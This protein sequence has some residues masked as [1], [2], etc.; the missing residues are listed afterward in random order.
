MNDYALK[1]GIILHGTNYNYT[2]EKVLGNGSFG[3]TYLA[4]VQMKGALGSL[5]ANISVAIKE[6]FMRDFNGRDECTVTYSSSDG[7]FTN[8]YKSRFIQEAKNLSKLHN[9]NIIKVIELFE[10]NQTAYY[11]MEYLPKGNFNDYIAAHKKLSAKDCIEYALQISGALDYMHDNGMLHLDLK[12]NNIMI[13]NNG[14]LVL[15]DFGLSKCFDQHG[16]PE[17]ST[18]IGHGTPGYAPIEQANYQ[19]TPNEG[20]PAT[21]DIYAF[22]AT[23]FKM[24]TGR[25]PPEASVILNDSFPNNDLV[26]INV[27]NDV[28]SVVRKCMQPIRNNRY[29]SMKDVI[30]AL[31]SI[32]S[33]FNDYEQSEFS[34]RGYYR[35]GVGERE[36]GTYQIKKIPVTSAIEFPNSINIRLWDNTGY[37]DSYE[38]YLTDIFSADGD[39]FSQNSI[40]FWHHG[41]F[42]SEYDFA[43]GIPSDVKDFIIKNGLLSTVHWELEDITTPIDNN[44]G[45]NLCIT[46]YNG[47]DEPFIRHVGNAHKAFHTI[48]LDV[49]Q[50]LLETTSLANKLSE[51]R[52]Q[53][54]THR[55]EIPFDS[56]S[57]SVKYKPAFL[58]HSLSSSFEYTFQTYPNIEYNNLIVV[59]NLLPLI[60]DINNLDIKEGMTLNDSHDYSEDPAELVI[61]VQSP[62]K[63]SILL[64]LKA[65]NRDMIAGNIYHAK[66]TDLAES[67]H[68][69][70]LKYLPK[71][72]EPTQELIYSIPE[73]T[74]EIRI[75]YSEGGIIGLCPNP[76]KIRIVNNKRREG[77]YS[78]EEL[79]KIAIGLQNLKLRSKEKID[80]EPSTGI[81]F[82]SLTLS[83]VDSH[84]KIL[85]ELYAQDNGNEMIGNTAIRVNDLKDELSKLSKS[86]KDS[87]AENEQNNNPKQSASKQTFFDIIFDIIFCTIILGVLAIPNFIFLKPT[88]KLFA[89]LWATFGISELFISILNMTLTKFPKS[90]KSGEIFGLLG[91]LSLIAYI[92]LWITQIF[93]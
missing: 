5:D 12:P 69:I 17:T 44:F 55:I 78:P 15:I 68:R 65:F 47:S 66:I 57:I 50:E 67:I 70:V 21:M 82:P 38:I 81:V 2:I 31:K 60:R 83:F 26:S 40:K 18:T 62:S 34:T 39:L 42:V 19:G 56:T 6:F 51:V 74:S 27:P 84:G 32:P 88:D 77:I 92:I 29:K 9:S 7:A 64:F 36:Y 93:I 20:F 52:K 11:V 48:L 16:K 87:L 49:I 41:H 54:N 58:M 72:H 46:M 90:K 63:G 23:M 33:S 61:E 37:G 85:K 86:F 1:P 22:G 10:E 30:E 71:D 91:L 13:N 25:R 73:S 28:I 24:L 8:Y 59:D 4:K 14:N 45:T 3:I 53:V 75:I 43:S 89:G 76:I 79:L 80:I 35:K